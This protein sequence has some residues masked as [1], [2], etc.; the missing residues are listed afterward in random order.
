M[1]PITGCRL[2]ACFVSFPCCL[3]DPLSFSWHPGRTPEK[4]KEGEP[5]GVPLTAGPGDLHF[6]RVVAIEVQIP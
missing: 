4:C 3:F 5:G 1:A 6:K 2:R